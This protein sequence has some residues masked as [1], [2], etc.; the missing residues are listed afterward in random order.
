MP[1][2]AR[3]AVLAFVLAFLLA[4]P[5]G[6][7]PKVIKD[8][9]EY[10][11]YMAAYEQ[12]DAAKRAAA[13]EAF[14]GKY[15]QSAVKLDALELALA[16]FQQAGNRD[17]VAALADEILKVDPDNLRAIA[18]HAFLL[19]ARATGEDTQALAQLSPQVERGLAL[20]GKWRK[21]QGMS[22]ADAGKL[23]RQLA[24]I[25]HGAA[26][27]VALQDKD[28][29]RARPHYLEAVAGD[30]NDLQNVYQLSLACLEATPVEPDGFWYVARA[31]VLAG[32]SAHADVQDSLKKYATAKYRRY[33][34]SDEGWNDLL[35]K[36]AKS[37]AK[38]ADFSVK[39][40]P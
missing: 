27:F 33:H 15:P 10:K 17:K 7:Q 4:L 21:P 13:M 25:L 23:K 16:G 24:T 12:K 3:R 14:A 34:G 8:Q 37:S 39:P 22:D 11:A 35:A 29:A 20:L 9:A 32:S 18:I 40:Q 1:D 26:G 19:R 2:S 28:Y 38:P 5:A 31:I 30:P 6:A 36:A